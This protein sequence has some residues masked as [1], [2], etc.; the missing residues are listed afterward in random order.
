LR[1]SPSSS[2]P[3]AGPNTSRRSSMPSA[4]DSAGH[5]TALMTFSL[6]EGSPACCGREADHNTP[7]STLLS[8]VSREPQADTGR[9][10]TVA[11]AGV[12]EAEEAIAVAAVATD[13]VAATEAAPGVGADR[14]AT[15]AAAGV[16]EAEEAAAVAAVATDRVAAT[17]ERYEGGHHGPRGQ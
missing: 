3:G 15:V 5:I 11:A 6:L 16:A 13:R 7:A 8:D 2:I 14:V 17:A 12:A 4:A 1:S 10:A 9:V